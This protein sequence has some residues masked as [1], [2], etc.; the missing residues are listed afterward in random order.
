[1]TKFTILWHYIT[2]NILITLFKYILVK[3]LEVI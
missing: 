3:A 2:V 1:M